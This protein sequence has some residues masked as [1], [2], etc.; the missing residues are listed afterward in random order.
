MKWSS[1]ATTSKGSPVSVELDDIDMRKKFGDEKWDAMSLG[2]QYKQ[3]AATA[4]V[5]VLD[6]L[7]THGEISDEFFAQRVGEIKEGLS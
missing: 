4:D 6:Y 7:R 1:G 3:I 5:F 2:D